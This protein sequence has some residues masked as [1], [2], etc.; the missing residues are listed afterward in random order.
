M[1]HLVKDLFLFAQRNSKRSVNWFDKNEAPKH[2]PKPVFHQKRYM[3]TVWW[4][5]KGTIDYSFLKPEETIT[6][7]KYCQQLDELHKK[8]HE[9]QPA[10]VNRNGPIHLH[11]NA[12]Q[13]MA[14]VSQTKLTILQRIDSCKIMQL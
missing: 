11:D 7:L 1:K 9:E 10:L 12:R 2:F 6:A 4:T 13:H 8:W 5:A 3:V 14:I